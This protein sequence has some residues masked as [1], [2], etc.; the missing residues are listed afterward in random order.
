MDAMEALLTRRSVR[1][2][3]EGPVDEALI[4]R[5]LQAAMAAPSAGN[6]QPWQ[7][8]VVDDRRILQEIPKFH[9]YAK[10]LLE[11]PLAIIVCSDGGQEGLGRYWPQDCAAATENLLLA[12]H[13]LGLGAVWLGIYPEEDRIQKLS[14]LL[15]LPRG[16][17]PFC[18]VSVGRPAKTRGP[19]DRYDSRRVHRNRW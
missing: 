7:F 11:A 17:T 5:M 16:V 6:Q 12:A 4:E 3:L 9:E 1:S 14:Q 10:M 18:V 8:V 13:A 2:Y 15:G 19:S